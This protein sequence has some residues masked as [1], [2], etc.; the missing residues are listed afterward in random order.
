[1]TQVSYEFEHGAKDVIYD[2][3]DNETLIK[4]KEHKC[5][6]INRSCHTVTVKIRWL[7][8]T[9]AFKKD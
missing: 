4:R 2:G 5:L 8:L 7:L 6:L 3:F 1:M 9:Q